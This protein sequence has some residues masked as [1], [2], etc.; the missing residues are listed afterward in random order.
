VF[1]AKLAPRALDLLEIVEL[2]WHDCYGEISPSEGLVDDLLLVSD[3][4][5]EGLVEAAHLALTDWRDLK[6]AAI[7]KRAGA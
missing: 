3:G 7:A 6:M 5:I 2:A 1:G 4:S